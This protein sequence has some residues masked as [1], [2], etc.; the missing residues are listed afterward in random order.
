MQLY[1]IKN[2]SIKS[3]TVFETI[4][5]FNVTNLKDELQYFV[6]VFEEKYGGHIEEPQS[7][8]GYIDDGSNENFADQNGYYRFN[9]S[10]S[11]GWGGEHHKEMLALK[12]S[13]H[14][15]SDN[16]A[17]GEIRISAAPKY[18]SGTY[19]IIEIT[20]RD[21]AATEKSIAEYNTTMNDI[22]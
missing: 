19:G 9:V 1:L 4:T 17:I 2:C 15:K 3:K 10:Y 16:K 11:K 21:Y 14:R 18:D 7:E 22:L 12:Y 5:W 6:K 13:I 8:L 20:Y